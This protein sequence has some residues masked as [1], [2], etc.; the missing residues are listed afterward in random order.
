MTLA[1]SIAALYAA[2]AEL[3]RPTYIRHAPHELEP[4]E[5]QQLLSVPLRELSPELMQS[6]LFE[7]VYYDGSWDDFRY[8]LPRILELLPC[9]EVDLEKVAWQLERGQEQSFP[10]SDAQRAALHA[11][12][13]AYWGDMLPGFIVWAEGY[14][15]CNTLEPFGVTRPEVL[16]L[17]RAHPQGALALAYLLWLN[18]SVPPEWPRA[19]VMGWLEEARLAAPDDEEAQVFSDALLILEHLPQ[20]PGS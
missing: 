18:G 4:G 2:F 6:Y 10:L 9:K 1:Q 14:L 15:I 3:P 17:W 8:Y 16:A 7:A 13:L 19:E 12:V 20:S 5:V 11:F